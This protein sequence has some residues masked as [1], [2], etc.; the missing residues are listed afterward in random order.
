MKLKWTP[1][2]VRPESGDANATEV[3]IAP[4]AFPKVTK[5]VTDK[6]NT[7]D[8]IKIVRLH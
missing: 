1:F 2:V 7:I 8:L 5:D 6:S 4:N 3:R